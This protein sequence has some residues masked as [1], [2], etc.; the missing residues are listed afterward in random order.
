MMIDAMMMTLAPCAKILAVLAIARVG[1]FALGDFLL[2]HVGLPFVDA[3]WRR[4]R[5]DATA[6]VGTR[7]AQAL[8]SRSTGMSRAV[9]AW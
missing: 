2:E 8:V 7:S 3:A 5:T 6:T 1:W 9:R 4:D